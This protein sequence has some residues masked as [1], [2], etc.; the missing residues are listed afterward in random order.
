MP[1]I[2]WHYSPF[3]RGSAREAGWE[4]GR[5]TVMSDSNDCDEINE[6]PKPEY[7]ISFSYLMAQMFSE[8]ESKTLFC[9]VAECQGAQGR[10][11]GPLSAYSYL[12]T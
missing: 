7:C 12:F 6:P 8:P 10:R 1:V 2:F 9:L 3:C 5:L 11:A 4:W